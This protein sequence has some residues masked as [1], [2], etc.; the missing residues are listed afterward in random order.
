MTP[1]IC[2]NCRSSGQQRRTPSR[3]APGDDSIDQACTTGIESR[4][5]KRPPGSIRNVSSLSNVTRPGAAPIFAAAVRPI[6][7][8][9]GTVMV[10]YGTHDPFVLV[11]SVRAVERVVGFGRVAVDADITAITAQLNLPLSRVVARVAKTLQ[12]ARDER[13]PVALMRRDV[14][15]SV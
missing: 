7:V 1:G 8:A 13:G 3:G 10:R 2:A 4:R 9:D 5:K 15:C 14:I 6:A 12:L 11:R